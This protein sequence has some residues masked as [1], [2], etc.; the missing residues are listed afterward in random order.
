MH[1]RVTRF[2]GSPSDVDKGIK[3]IKDEII[4][5]A[6]KMQG[7]KN[8]YWLID[9]MSGKGVAITLFDSESSVRSSEGSAEQ[10]RKVASDAGFRIAGVDRYEVIAQA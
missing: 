9:R 8:G 10:S 4:P 3:L 6:K 2:E 1:A 5:N 7:F